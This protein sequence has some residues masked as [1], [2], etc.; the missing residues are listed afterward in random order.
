M[1]KSPSVVFPPPWTSDVLSKQPDFGILKM[2][3]GTWKNHVTTG[4][5]LHTTSM[6]SPG[7]NS[8]QIPGKFH[9]VCEDYVETLTFTPINDSVRNRGGANEQF[10]GVLQYH[11][12]IHRSSDNALLHVE[13]GMYLW[14]ESIYLRP[15]TAETIEEDLGTPEMG[16]GAGSQGPVFVPAQTI[17]RSGSIPHG[18]TINLIGSPDMN[19][20][21]LEMRE[22][23]PNDYEKFWKNITGEGTWPKNGVDEHFSISLS[24]GGGGGPFNLDK[25][26]PDRITN[27][28]VLLDDP[29]SNIAYTQRI[30]THNLYPYSVRPDLRLRDVAAKQKIKHFFTFSLD[31]RV[32]SSQAQGTA[33][34]QGGVINVPFVNRYTPCTRARIRMWIEIVEEDCQDFLQLQYEQIS[35]FE[36][37]FGT[38]GGTTVWPHIQVN[39]L[40]KVMSNC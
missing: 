25:P 39:T 26:A 16:V 17:C 19:K 24:M 8:E 40:R 38:D 22:G 37:G 32:Q 14:M 20:G 2:L 7:S 30:V 15:A 13:N 33:G 3:E 11:Q 31:T 12:L 9:F 10:I 35:Q 23:K 36:F 18:S 6:P 4:P 27:P 1:E 5:G 29:S 34:P 21:K 28:I